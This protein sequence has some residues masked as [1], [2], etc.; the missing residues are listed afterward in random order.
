MATVSDNPRYEKGEVTPEMIDKINNF[1]QATLKEKE[2]EWVGYKK[3]GKWLEEAGIL[4]DDLP[5]QGKRFRDV[6]KTGKIKGWV[7]FNGQ[8]TDWVVYRTDVDNSWT[9]KMVR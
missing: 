5:M 2:M 3:A 9:K 1:L 7:K 8:S 4:A 6:L